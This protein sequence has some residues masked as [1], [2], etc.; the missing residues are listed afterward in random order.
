MSLRVRLNLLLIVLFVF[1]LATGSVYAI[2]GAR[3]V[4]REETQSAAR[5]TSILVE[6]NIAAAQ[7]S[8]ASGLSEKLLRELARLEPMRH[9]RIVINVDGDLSANP[10]PPPMDADAPAWFVGLVKPPATYFRRVIANEEALGAAITIFADPSA[11]IAEAWRETRNFLL[12]LVLFTALANLAIYFILGRDL[13]PIEA[14][15]AGL[16]RIEQGDYRL[17]LPAFSTTEL[18]RISDRFNHMAAVL[19]KSREENKALTRRSLEIQEQERRYLARELHDE[20]GQSLSAIKAVATSMEQAGAAGGAATVDA[21]RVIKK[22]AE[23]MYGVARGLMRRLRPAALDQ[24]GLAP[25]LQE[26]VDDWNAA[27]GETFCHLDLQGDCAGL[28]D[29]VNINV[30]RI[31]QEGLTNAAK[32]GGAK[33]VRALVKNEGDAGLLLQISDDGKGFDPDQ[34]G[35]GLGL[36]GIRERVEVMGGE[37]KLETGP[38]QGVKIAITLPVQWN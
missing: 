35:K 17:R 11:E 32:H 25:T 13:A 29:E 9:Q 27:H 33:N 36:R 30:Y 5:L 10:L 1:V 3:K 18:S 8:G 22:T 23:E 12:L 34:A 28:A 19:L 21:A 20:L 31:I 7:E 15:L 6:A 14:I 37:F 4:V 16:E 38:N 24:L 2:Q 26:L